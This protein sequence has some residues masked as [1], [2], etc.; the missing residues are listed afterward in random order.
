[1]EEQ[2][3][4]FFN[5]FGSGDQD[6]GEENSDYQSDSKSEPGDA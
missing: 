5:E 6:E 4:E 1:M 2:Q 3:K